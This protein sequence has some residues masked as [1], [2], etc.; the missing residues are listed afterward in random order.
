MRVAT[1][2]VLCVF[3]L[4]FSGC[5]VFSKK[6]EAETIAS[7]RD[8]PQQVIPDRPIERSRAQAQNAY[9]SILGTSL[10]SDI[11]PEVMR[12]L[13]DM[14]TDIDAYGEDEDELDPQIVAEAIDLYKGVLSEYPDYEH[15]EEVLYQLARIYDQSS[16][17]EESQKI[18]DQLVA[19]YP[20]SVHYAEAQFRRGEFLFVEQKYAQAHQAYAQVYKNDSSETNMHSKADVARDNKNVFREPAR[21]KKGWANF[22]QNKYSSALDDFMVILDERLEKG[23]PDFKKLSRAD[24]ERVDDTLRAVSLC[25]VYQDGVNSLTD[26]FEA[27][28]AKQY[29]SLVYEKLAE[30][31]SDKKRHPDTAKIYAAFLDRNPWHEQAPEFQTMVVQNL[32]KGNYPRQELE[33]REKYVELFAPES[34]Y[35]KYYPAEKHPEVLAQVKTHYTDLGKHYHSVAQ[36]SKSSE[37]FA[38]SQQWYKQYIAAFPGEKDTASTHFLLAES[39]YQSGQIGAAVIAWNSTAYE[40]PEHELSSRAAYSALL[41]YQELDKRSAEQQAGEDA[42]IMT[43]TW[44]KSAIKFNK[45]F[46]QH[47]KSNEVLVSVAQKMFEIKDYTKAMQVAETLLNKKPKASLNDRK[48]VWT[49]TGHS[50]FEKKSFQQAELG[51]IEAL[52][53]MPPTDPLRHGVSERLAA[54]VYKQAESLRDKGNNEEAVK[55]FLRVASVAPTAKVAAVATYDAAAVLIKSA[56][57]KQATAILENFRG[58]YLGHKLQQEVD[59]NLATAY[60]KTE[61]PAKAA[62]E[63]ERLATSDATP[64]IRQEALLN[65]SDL[66]AKSGDELKS[67]FVLER[68]VKKFPTPVEPAAEAAYKLAGFYAKRHDTRNSSEWYKQVIA[69][70]KQP[71]GNS[72]RIRFLAAKSGLALTKPALEAYESVFLIQPLKNNL[73]KKKKLMQNLLAEYGRLADYKIAEITTETTYRSGY[74]YADFSKGIL[75]SEKPT[76]LDADTFD[77]YELLLEEQAIPFEEQAIEVHEINTSRISDG[78]YDEW[79]KK[80]FEALKKLLPVRYNKEEEDGGPITRIH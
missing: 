16:Q 47:E 68:Y 36:K 50:Q 1:V 27:K 64:E 57:W 19:G 37:D 3:L 63:F 2:I 48:I 13:A 38:K 25:F 11:N 15:R 9:R 55:Q 59:K 18:L 52:K 78:V 77:E 54:S 60:L 32:R 53:L 5:S 30:Y 70:S 41:G 33:A 26:Y 6:Q 67:I 62:A 20:D 79:V 23:L 8:R 17:I 43:E 72:D 44:V 75:E 76:N 35:W 73:K 10:K 28:G 34:E 4:L 12:R 14:L 42:Q 22:K 39:Y 58:K 24:R 31:Y 71:G 80:S 61:Q 69:S 29:E 46:P 7:L 74:I 45:S 65:A 51:Y 49:I 56:K 66:Y 21:Y 40:Y